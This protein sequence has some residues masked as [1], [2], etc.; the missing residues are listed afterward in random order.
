MGLGHCVHEMVDGYGLDFRLRR[1]GT[2]EIY[3]CLLVRNVEPKGN[4]YIVTY[5]NSCLF[6][7]VVGGIY[8]PAGEEMNE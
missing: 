3:F 6:P 2:K 4:R 8:R 1:C 5:I 7:M